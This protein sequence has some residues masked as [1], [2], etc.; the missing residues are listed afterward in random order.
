VD[1]FVVVELANRLARQLERL[2]PDLLFHG[3]PYLFQRVMLLPCPEGPIMKENGLC[4]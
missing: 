2:N 1:Q 3:C 4:G